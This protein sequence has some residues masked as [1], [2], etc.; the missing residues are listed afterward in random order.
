MYKKARKEIIKKN[1]I[2]L[3]ENRVYDSKDRQRK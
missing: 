2:Q 3:Q 1:E